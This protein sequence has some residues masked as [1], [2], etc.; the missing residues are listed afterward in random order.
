VKTFVEESILFCAA[1]AVSLL[2]C[3]VGTLLLIRDRVSGAA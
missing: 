1:A 2:M 3:V